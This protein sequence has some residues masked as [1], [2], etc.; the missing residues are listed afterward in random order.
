MNEQLQRHPE[1]LTPPPTGYATK[2]PVCEMAVRPSSYAFQS[3][4]T[5]VR[6]SESPAELRANSPQAL[7]DYQRD[8]LERTVLFWDTLRQR[9]DNML[10]HERAGLPPLLDFK[11]E[12][13]L[14]A[15]R[16]EHPVNRLCPTGPANRA[17]TRCAS[18]AVFLAAP[19]LRI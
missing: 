7:L 1:H 4:R 15:R 5:K 8:L 17:S 6:P 12:T 9:A 13:L 14:D 10:E 3:A 18:P 11:Y 2:D 16:F 19:G